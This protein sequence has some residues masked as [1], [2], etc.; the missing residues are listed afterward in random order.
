MDTAFFIKL[1]I[2]ITVVIVLSVVA[3][4]SS[5][6]IAGIL[7][8]YPTGTAITL[9][10]YGYQISP[11]FAADSAVFN[12]IG[13]VAMQAFIYF[14][15]KVSL[16]LNIVYSSL[17]AIAGYLFVIWMLHFIELNKFVSVF[18]PIASIFLFL[19]LFRNINNVTVKERARLS[20]KA[21]FL[22]ALLAASIILFVTGIASTVGST[23]S[24]L[25]SA[26]PSTLFPLILI[27]HYTYDTK[28]VHAVIKNVPVG[29]LSLVL[30]SLTLSIVY[31]SMGIYWGTLAGFIVA[32]A[33]LIV[34]QIASGNKTL[35]RLLSSV[36]V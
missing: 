28:H 9:F 29:I 8:G 23:W 17:I 1:L 34:Y 15:Y 35:K 24:G 16:K 26:F 6:R 3:E 10:F 22:R 33:Y 32:T 36:E 4:R 21:L 12:M 14:Y 7:S 27:V 13:L 18:I 25:F 30:Y 11:Q 20:Q 31:P 2:A 19:Y 5:P